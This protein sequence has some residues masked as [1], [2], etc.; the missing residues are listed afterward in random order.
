PAHLHRPQATLPRQ[1]GVERREPAAELL[2][3][4][5]RRALRDAD[6]RAGGRTVTR[7]RSL[8][9]LALAAVAALTVAAPAAA[10]S[11]AL[12]VKKV[13]T[14]H[15]PTVSVTV[16]TPDPSATPELSVAENG[17]TAA[18]VRQ[19]DSGAAAAVAVVID[20]SRSM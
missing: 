17:Q 9:A 4:R 3:G 15:W 12:V 18:G 14:S 10:S 7:R 6:L 5:G 8:R 16:Q 11:S 2:P 20:T 19:Q 1:D 13:D